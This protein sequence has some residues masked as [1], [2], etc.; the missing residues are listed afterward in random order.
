[1]LTLYEAPAFPD[2][3]LEIV[4]AGE[5]PAEPVWARSGIAPEPGALVRFVLP[6]GF[7]S[8][9]R[10]EIRLFGLEG[11]ERTLLATYTVEV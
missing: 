1:M 11:E 9:G 2:Y 4:S 10:Y 5:G 6:A 8:P 3:R 7:L